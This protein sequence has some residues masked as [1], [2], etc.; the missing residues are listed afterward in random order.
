MV[1]IADKATLLFAALIV[2]MGIAMQYSAAN[3]AWRP[4]A[5][6]QTTIFVVTIPM[7]AAIAFAGR[8]AIYRYSYHAYVLTLALLALVVVGGATKMGATRWLNVGGVTLQPSELAKIT[9]IL[10]L[11]RYLHSYNLG[12]GSPLIFFVPPLLIL[13]VPALLI[14]AQP[15]LGNSALLLT[16]GIAIIVAVGFP[17]RTLVMIGIAVAASLPL[18]WKFALHKY[19]KT[20]LLSFL[21]PEGDPLGSGYNIIQS[22]IAAG[23]GG[24]WGKGFLHGSQ[25]HLGFLPEKHTDFIFT[26]AAEEFGLVGCVIVLTLYTT[27]AMRLIFLGCRSEEKFAKL[28]VFGIASM[29]LIQALTNIGMTLGLLPVVGV[30]L[31]LMSYGGSSLV[32]SLIG[33]T[34]AS[35]LART[36]KP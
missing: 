25:T 15:H 17:L 27:L 5:S 19:Q 3:G 31:P 24:I 35:I 32:A 20:R 12:P 28:A 9:T 23:S 14:F 16:V 26:I 1:I 2:V 30:P 7:A 33:L 11:A 4:W 29:L 21:N 34:I 13:A 36:A 18:V 22:K 10:A 6:K 8:E